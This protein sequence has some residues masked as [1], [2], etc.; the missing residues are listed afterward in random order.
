MTHRFRARFAHSRGL[1]SVRSS[2]DFT[3]RSM[4]RT[5]SRLRLWPVL[6]LAFT[7]HSNAAATIGTGGGGDVPFAEHG[8][9]YLKSHCKGAGAADCPFGKVRE[10]SYVHGVLGAFDIAYPMAFLS[11]K[12][13]AEELQKI[14]TGLLDLQTHWIDWLSKADAGAATAKADINELKAWV[15]AWKPASFSKNATERDLFALCGANEAQKT[16]AKKLAA[17]MTNPASLGVGPKDSNPVSILF[18]P[19]RKDFVELL[20]YAGTIDPA[21]QAVLWNKNAT[22]WGTFWIDQT[23]V[24][25]LTYPAWGDDPEFKSDLSMNK[26]EATGMLQYVVQQS[27]IGLLWA[28]Y[29]ETDALYFT[30]AMGLNMA[31][32]VCGECNALEG[33][34]SRGTTGAHT[35]PY[36]KFV[37]GGN[38][39]GGMLPPIPASPFD[40]MIMNQW[41]TGLGRDHFAAP[42]RKGQKASLKEVGGKKEPKLEPSLAKDKIAHF[43]LIGSDPSQKYVVTAPFFGAHSKEKPYPPPEVIVDYREFF[44]AYRSAFYY[45]LQTTGDPK[46]PDASA[47]KYSELMKALSARPA[48]KTFDDVVKELYGVQLSDK[49]GEKDSLEWRFLKWLDKGK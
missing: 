46:G 8:K 24:I 9:A 47:Q 14:S 17:F 1:A 42:L 37:P 12:D 26:F 5:F 19:T 27:T 11:E 31:I 48:D 35:D 7:L 39:S 2:S 18:S 38:S 23:L 29:G 6:L 21:Q 16:A 3:P 30:A 13:K 15:K 34:S 49:N 22:T 25:G 41:R 36:E 33:D 40:A 20:G 4:K 45:W 32:A 43:L 44:R 10:Q 28:C